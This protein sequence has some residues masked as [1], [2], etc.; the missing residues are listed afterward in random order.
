MSLGIPVVEP[1]ASEPIKTS[2]PD[3]PSDSEGK[4]SPEIWE[5]SEGK[6]YL[7][8][9]WE[10]TEAWQTLSPDEQSNAELIS[11][12]F[13]ESKDYRKDEVGYR[14]FLKKYEHLTDTKSAPLQVKINKISEFIRYV[15]RTS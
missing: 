14:D 4:L 13:R 9:L 3:R 1:Q 12:H 15:K 6:P 5:K 2:N 8:K 11:E 10:A 7:T